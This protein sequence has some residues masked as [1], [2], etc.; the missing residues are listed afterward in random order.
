VESACV[1]RR[2]ARAAVRGRRESHTAGE[3]TAQTCANACFRQLSFLASR[4]IPFSFSITSLCFQLR[5]TNRIEQEIVLVRQES[6]NVHSA[7][8][9]HI[10]SAIG[11][12]WRHEFH[13]VACTVAIVGG[14]G[15]VPV[16]QGEVGRVISV[17]DGWAGARRWYGNHR[18]EYVRGVRA[19]IAVKALIN[20]PQK[21]LRRTSG[22]H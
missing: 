10:D 7:P 22:G 18:A 19:C 3:Q 20:G 9:A 14:H 2:A 8:G 16:F 12:G 11:H 1:E 17:Q 6:V 4:T 5:L 21:T 13:S 15:T